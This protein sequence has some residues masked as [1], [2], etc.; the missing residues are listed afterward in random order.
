[1]QKIKIIV[2]ILFLVIFLNQHILAG[3]GANIG[4]FL[5]LEI[6]A[7]ETAMAGAVSAVTNDINALF[8]N[9]AGLA[10]V[11]RK[12][13]T[14]MYNNYFFDLSQHYLAYA[15]S[16]K[17]D[18]IRLGF[19]INY[20]DYGKYDK[21]RIN[22]SDLEP[23]FDGQRSANSFA[24]TTG[25]AKKAS[26]NINFGAALKT[27]RFDFGDIARQS[28]LLDLGAQYKGYYKY[29]N[30]SAVLLNIG[31]GIKFY[32]IEEKFPMTIKLGAAYNLENFFILSTDISK[33]RKENIEFALG[34]ELRPID[35]FAIRA[36]YDNVADDGSGWSFGAGVSINDWSVNFAYKPFDILGNV[37]KFDVHY[38]FGRQLPIDTFEKK[39]TAIQPIE[40]KEKMAITQQ[41]PQSAAV[42][43]PEILNFI[44]VFDNNVSLIF[45]DNTLIGMLLNNKLYTKILDMYFTPY[46]KVS[47]PYDNL[48]V[49]YAFYK[50][51]RFEDAYRFIYNSFKDYG[52]NINVQILYMDAL[53][54][55]ENYEYLK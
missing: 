41:I 14:F 25:I 32:K 4:Q 49:G 39:E 42:S 20:F 52:N 16:M 24:F 18:P 1:M 22:Q 43:I 3:A 37:T 55:A 38:K 31:K 17:N 21:I 2:S 12:E 10:D 13:L 26:S 47:T 15:T 36:G 33:I 30:F 5:N 34:A 7:R 19:Y 27:V 6:G 29:F 53:L 8:F 35:I 48:I 40:K 51:N 50:L 54:K 28:Y 46:Y 11:N 23:L 9:P 44:Y 45:A